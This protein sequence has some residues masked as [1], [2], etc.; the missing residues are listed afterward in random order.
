MR[1]AFGLFAVGLALAGVAPAWSERTNAIAEPRE[2]ANPP[3]SW[4]CLNPRTRQYQAL[5]AASLIEA[6]QIVGGDSSTRCEE[7]PVALDPERVAH[8]LNTQ[9]STPGQ[10][11]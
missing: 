3:M 1:V 2:V 6:R 9:Q 5:K 8:E 11:R 4:V 10:S 7:V